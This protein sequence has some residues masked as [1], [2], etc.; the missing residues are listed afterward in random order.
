MLIV[1]LDWSDNFRSPRRSNENR[2]LAMFQLAGN[3][4]RELGK[5]A[6]E[7]NGNAVLGVQQYFDLEVSQKAI[8]VR[9]IG[10]A[11]KIVKMN[12]A[13]EIPFS[14]LSSSPQHFQ[15]GS[16]ISPSML[17][18]PSPKKSIANI[19]PL[20]DEPDPHIDTIPSLVLPA[21]N[22]RSVE[23]V[24]LTIKSFPKNSLVAMVMKY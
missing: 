24:F 5:K 1:F 21:S 2:T 14:I 16:T 10:T 22:W 13:L 19:S 17:P 9:S 7:L 12:E 3:C 4:R 11:V 23:P 8:T 18:I 15:R 20:L 6:L